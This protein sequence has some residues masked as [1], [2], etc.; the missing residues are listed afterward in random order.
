MVYIEINSIVVKNVIGYS[1]N[2][3]RILFAKSYME[4]L[5]SHMYSTA[6]N[7]HTNRKYEMFLTFKELPIYLEKWPRDIYTQRVTKSR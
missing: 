1:L 3:S 2:I 6:M 4:T 5:S 7:T